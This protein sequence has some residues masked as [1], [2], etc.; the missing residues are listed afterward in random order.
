MST[1]KNNLIGNWAYCYEGVYYEMYISDS[2]IYEFNDQI[3]ILTQHE[4]NIHAP[5]II[6]SQKGDESNEK[7]LVIEILDSNRIKLVNDRL[8]LYLHKINGSINIPFYEKESPKLI[9]SHEKEFYQRAEKFR[10]KHK[11][12][13]KKKT[14]RYLN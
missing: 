4:Y 12:E 8:E 11:C 1:E 13:Q 10:Y 14:I 5:T 3:P 6:I 7:Q 2:L 9:E